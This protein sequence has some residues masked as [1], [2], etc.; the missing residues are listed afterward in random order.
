[1]SN[2]K[3]AES[4]AEHEF[5]IFPCA[6]GEKTPV[7]PHGC[8]DATADVEQIH[9]W[10]T[11]QPMY[12]IG[13]HAAG[14]LIVDIDPG[15]EDWLESLEPGQLEEL[16]KAP[17]QDTPRGGRHFLYL[18][19]DGIEVKNSAGK[20]APNVDVRST[21]GYI[22]AS[23]S[24]VGGKPYS[25]DESPPCRTR[26][27]LAPDW[28]IEMAQGNSQKVPKIHEP[29]ERV[30][31]GEPPQGPILEG[32][33]D[34]TLITL[35]GYLRNLGLDTNAVFAALWEVNLARCQPPMDQKEIDR[36]AK[37]S[38]RFE[39]DD[40]QAMLANDHILGEICWNMLNTG[41]LPVDP[42][43]LTKGVAN[44]PHA[45]D[46]A[47]PHAP[48]GV[49]D[50]VEVTAFYEE[51][52]GEEV[53]LWAP[54]NER[55]Y[56]DMPPIMRQLFDVVKWRSPITNPELI[57]ASMLPLFGTFYGHRAFNP[58]YGTRTNLYSIGLG[59][60]GAGKD[61]PRTVGMELFDLVNADMLA[62]VDVGSHVGLFKLLQAEPVRMAYID[63]MG[64]SLTRWAQ[65]PIG[66]SILS[67]LMIL[68]TESD[69]VAWKPT[70]VKDGRGADPVPY[71]CM[72]FYGTS[73]PEA[74]FRSLDRGV[75]DDGFMGRCLLFEEA[76]D[77]K[78]K[79]PNN[80]IEIP[81][82]VIE[83][84]RLW[85]D[86]GR[87]NDNLVSLA[88]PNW[89][90]VP[91][92]A[93]ASAFHEQLCAAIDSKSENEN[94]WRKA[95]WKR[96]GEKVTKLA[97]IRAC[98]GHDFNQDSDSDLKISLRDELWAY[99]IVKRSNRVQ[100]R[101]L[102]RMNTNPLIGPMRDVYRA[103]PADGT[104]VKRALAFKPLK[105]MK[106]HD[107]NA[108]I[109]QLMEFD[110]IEMITLPAKGGKA[111]RPSLRVRRGPIKLH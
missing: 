82:E 70:I 62:G 36:I 15:G 60:T 83:H 8:K 53:E 98:A 26:L 57:I 41:Q 77:N 67:T 25:W 16:M 56:T 93:D 102:D 52:E 31:R 59:K 55:V 101:N 64:S 90:R 94:D 43:P 30:D 24:K 66:R 81:P 65:T 74:F 109:E 107:K 38:E 47:P 75:I 2:L 10:W 18:L 78:R 33:R 5:E 39:I 58:E 7:T 21:G 86:Y 96:T 69:K 48:P 45:P 61:K 72:S 79:I 92:D 110:H 68:Y 73:T 80:D 22:L 29:A 32:T 100:I 1:M 50:P 106:T 14:L 104:L 89:I 11:M 13:L 40:V 103:L 17:I 51:E 88:G 6:P 3:A 49:E 97:I 4:W 35:A 9:S 111:G 105:G 95:I 85:R 46:D 23:P 91:M 108:V 20:I 44:A 28:L 42:E 54:M 19:P 34:N 37:S 99:S 71:P 84:F 27:P 76:A 12:N 87:S 63:E